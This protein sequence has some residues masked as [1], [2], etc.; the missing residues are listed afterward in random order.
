MYN[1]ETIITFQS[2]CKTTESSSYLCNYALQI[3]EVETMRKVS[4]NAVNAVNKRRAP[5]NF[6]KNKFPS[7][8]IF[9]RK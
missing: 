5:I 4:A 2:F 9:F 8:S 1:S 3:L 6:Q 7:S